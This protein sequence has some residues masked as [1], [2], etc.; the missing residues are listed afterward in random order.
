[1]TRCLENLYHMKKQ[2]MTLYNALVLVLLVFRA[3]MSS[4]DLQSLW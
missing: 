2:E 3:N 1:M 4:Y